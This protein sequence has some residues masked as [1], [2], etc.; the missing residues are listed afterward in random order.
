MTDRAV[1]DP[2]RRRLLTPLGP[3]LMIGLVSLLVHLARW[4][5][6]RLGIPPLPGDPLRLL[7]GVPLVLCGALLAAACAA[8][9]FRARGTPVPFNPPKELVVAG[10]YRWSRNPMMTG[11]FAALLGLAVLL[12]SPALAGVYL[13]AFALL[14]ALEIRYV[15]E[16]ELEQRFGEAYRRYKASTPRFLPRPWRG[17]APPAAGVL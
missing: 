12:R 3:L 8:R 10:P 7:L 1:A 5:D 11:L 4:T 17:G 13:P 2:R 14:M 6:R 16:P 9:F 15:E